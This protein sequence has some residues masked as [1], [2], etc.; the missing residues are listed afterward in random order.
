M[1]LQTAPSGHFAWPSAYAAFIA[2]SAIYQLPQKQQFYA[3]NHLPTINAP[4]AHVAVLFKNLKTDT[5]KFQWLSQYRVHVP[6][7]AKVLL[8][9]ALE[10]LALRHRAGMLLSTNR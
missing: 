7:E 5:D 3:K 8:F 4:I 1:Q 10:I 2:W 6:R 9:M